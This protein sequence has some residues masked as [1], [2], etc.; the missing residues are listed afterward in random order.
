MIRAL[1]TAATGMRAQETNID[2]L[3]LENQRDFS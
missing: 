3:N 2:T 1:Y